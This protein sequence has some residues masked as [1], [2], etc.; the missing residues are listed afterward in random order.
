MA[1]QT[2]NDG[3]QLSVIRGI[4]NANAN[5]AEAR[6]LDVEKDNTMYIG[7]LTDLAPFLNAGTYELPHGSYE[8]TND[9]DFGTADILLT[10]VDKCYVFRG[11]CLPLISYSGVTP[12]I[13][14]GA[15]GI[16]LQ[17]E[18]AFYTTPNATC[19]DMMIGGN[20]LI[21]DIA[22][23]FACQ[24]GANLDNVD[25][26]TIIA[27]PIIAC[28]NGI[29]ANNVKTIT[30]RLP[31]FNTGADVGGSYLT[32]S[33]ASSERAILSSID[34]RPEAT[35]SFI[36]VTANY[37]GDIELGI[38]V[39]ATGGGTFFDASGRDQTDLDI[40]V[41]GIKNVADS[42]N[43]ASG[44]LTGNSTETIIATQSVPVKI[45]AVWTE[46]LSIRFT[47]N[48]T[49]TWTYV[50]KEDIFVS[51]SI[52]ATLDVS[53]GGTKTVDLYLA[54]NGVFIPTSKG[55]AA[56]SGASQV[57]AVALIQLSTGDTIEG[58]VANATDT[59]NITV[60]TAT[61]NAGG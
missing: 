61:F 54:K 37:G 15:T 35:E 48:A 58:W 34:S 29:I 46:L 36:N 19:V 7:S 1:Q 27:E 17:M 31:Q 6:L 43:A 42:S 26:L 11:Y 20:S 8:W 30:A 41:I 13:T 38:G 33:G 14:A 32:L 57:G 5:D 52:V 59:N 21:L 49:G 47:F 3:D 9:I 60:T 55:E 51:A 50:G 56:G 2:F 22:V 24:L 10:D 53:G 25:F 28:E 40:G 4:I 39:H 23:F 45:N 18:N 16:I 12:F 44:S